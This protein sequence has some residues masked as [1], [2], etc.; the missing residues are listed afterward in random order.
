[1]GMPAL[2]GEIPDAG[3]DLLSHPE[4]A[5]LL[6]HLLAA[7]DAS[8]ETLEDG[9]RAV[10]SIEDPEMQA[11]A[12]DLLAS[13]SGKNF[14]HQGR[15]RLRILEDAWRS[16]NA[17][18]RLSAAMGETNENEEIDALQAL[19]ALHAARHARKKS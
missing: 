12:A 10:A 15:D 13:G 5:D 16:K 11:L 6:S 2:L 14:A 4:A 1:M 8:G 19:V 17:Q 3:T 9:A 18:R 7:W